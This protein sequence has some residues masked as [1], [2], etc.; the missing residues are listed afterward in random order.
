LDKTKWITQKSEKIDGYLT[1]SLWKSDLKMDAHQQAQS[2][3]YLRNRTA[4][5]Y[6]LLS[7]DHVFEA[8]LESRVRKEEYEHGKKKRRKEEHKSLNKLTTGSLRPHGCRFVFIS[9]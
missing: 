8:G 7:Q 2:Q 1:S 6:R 3:D 9:T 5:G 4:D